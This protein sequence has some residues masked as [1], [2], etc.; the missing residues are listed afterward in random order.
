MQEKK[1]DFSPEDYIGGKWSKFLQ[2]ISMPKTVFTQ[3]VIRDA[4]QTCRVLI[5]RWR[6][7]PNL[8]HYSFIYAVSLSFGLRKRQP[9]DTNSREAEKK[10]LDLEVNLKQ[11]Q[12][13]LQ[14]VDIIAE[15][16]VP[17]FLECF[18]LIYLFPD[19][20]SSRRLLNCQTLLAS[21]CP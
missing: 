12:A 15:H 16:L 9:E 20:G 11:I 3:W 4:L 1:G 8:T 18:L 7:R 21:C 14:Q 10:R 2:L 17:F 19:L 13:W 6:P 5:D